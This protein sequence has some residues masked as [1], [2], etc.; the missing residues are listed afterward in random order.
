MRASID[1][2][3]CS[4]PRF[5]RNASGRPKIEGAGKGTSHG[6]GGRLPRGPAVAGRPQLWLIAGQRLYLFSREESRRSFAADPA[7]ILKHAQD[8]WPALA[9]TLSDY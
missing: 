3:N 5:T 2:W 6:A 9:A 1:C 7:A 4:W 8:R